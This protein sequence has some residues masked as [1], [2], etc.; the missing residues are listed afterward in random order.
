MRR[1][2]AAR[3]MAAGMARLAIAGARPRARSAFTAA[4]S[5]SNGPVSVAV[6][7]GDAAL[8]SWEAAQSEDLLGRWAMNLMLINVSTRRF[9]RAVRLPGGDIPAGKGDGGLEIGGLAPLRGAVGGTDEELD[10]GRSVEAGPAG[11]PDRR[12][13]HRAGP[14]P[15]GGCRH[16]RRKATSTR[17]ASWKG[18]PRTP[19]WSRRCSIT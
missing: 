9:G 5:R 2:Y 6:T 18:P 3:A 19:P 7:A 12:H 8:P 15:A 16:R 14:D 11:N 17:S 1:S 13:P 4:R 10:G